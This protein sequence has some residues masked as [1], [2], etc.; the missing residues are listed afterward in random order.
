MYHYATYN[1]GTS[2][3]EGGGACQ[4]EKD[5]SGRVLRKRPEGYSLRVKVIS[6][7]ATPGFP[8]YNTVTF[9]LDVGSQSNPLSGYPGSA[10]AGVSGC[11]YLRAVCL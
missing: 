11:P 9:V 10:V 2:Q 8:I 3:T 5:S 6:P 4:P 1:S 7:Y